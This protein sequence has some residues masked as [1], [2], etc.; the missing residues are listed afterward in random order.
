[1]ETIV[2]IEM[3]RFFMART[4]SQNLDKIITVEKI[5]NPSLANPR[6]NNI[7]KLLPTRQKN[8]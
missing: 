2:L 8:I 3:N 5:I 7:N 1:M 6:K 4:I